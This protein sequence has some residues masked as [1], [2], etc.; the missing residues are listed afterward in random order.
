MYLLTFCVLFSWIIESSIASEQNFSVLSYHDVV[1]T[2]SELSEDSVTLDHLVNQFEWLLAHHYHPVS[3]TD[4]LKARAGEKPLPSKSVLLTFDDGYQSF[5]SLV[6]PLLKAYQYPAV[7]ALVGSWMEVG[8]DGTVNYGKGQVPRNTLI[9]WDQAREL[10]KS[11][12]VEIA[13]HSYQLHGEVNAT[14][15]GNGLAAGATLTYNR[16][17]QN[18]ESRANYRARV[19]N[20]L[21]QAQA[22][23]N[24]RIGHSVRVLVWPY[25]R[26]TD[27]AVAAAEK[28]GFS[29]ALTLNREQGR[30][31]D[32]MHTGRNYVWRN[33][34]TLEYRNFLDQ[35][36]EKIV[37]RFPLLEMQ[38]LIE[39]DPH[40]EERLAKWLER[41]SQMKPDGVCIRPYEFRDGVV[42][43]FFPSQQL[44]VSQDRLL[45]TIW[46]TRTRGQTRSL[47]WLCNDR[48]SWKWG[49]RKMIKTWPEIGP[50]SPVFAVVIGG[51]ELSPAL[52]DLPWNQ[53]SALHQKISGE[54]P[55][56]RRHRRQVCLNKNQRSPSLAQQT[57]K[58]LEAFQQWQPDCQVYLQISWQ[59]ARAMSEDELHHLLMV[60][61][62]L[63]LDARGLSQR[64]LKKDIRQKPLQNNL[65]KYGQVLVDFKYND[66]G[67]AKLNTHRLTDKL[68][69][70]E[71]LGMVSWIYDHDWP[72]SG[73]PALKQVR[74]MISAE[75]FPW[76]D[77]EFRIW[78][79]V[80]KKEG[81]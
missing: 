34:T 43:A 59:Q 73:Q 18:Y 16:Q 11:E 20:D 74:P 66:R 21:K 56:M 1:L 52:L 24:E 26:Y 17:N 45:R 35:P 64:D 19:Q 3:V 31:D 41:C 30:L 67:F 48:P 68:K 78:S 79:E 49:D 51:P 13:S 22:N 7:L 28:E 37:G 39:N 32:L 75:G 2:R 5:Y 44:E 53:Y 62:R 65:A 58:N 42:K 71:G 46:Q 60:F 81:P 63:V 40:S 54:S 36:L 8:E 70:I 33:P 38:S 6:F 80:E 61:D 55:T 69:L 27:I 72:L 25:G 47:L 23:L 12:L 15:Q 14:A 50:M 29:M 57:L 76:N 10:D 9:S 4:I 77:P